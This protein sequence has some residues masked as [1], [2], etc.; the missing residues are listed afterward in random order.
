M[1]KLPQF[2]TEEEEIAWFDTH[3]TAEYMDEMEEVDETF[4]VILTRLTTRLTI[5]LPAPYVEAIRAYADRKGLT[6][7][8]VVRAWLLDRLRQEAPDLVPQQ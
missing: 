6:Y 1:P 4:D 5:K 2:N 8:T 7:Q 3:D